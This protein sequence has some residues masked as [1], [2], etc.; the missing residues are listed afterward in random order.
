MQVPDFSEVANQ[1][2][3]HLEVRHEEIDRA[4]VGLLCLF[5]VVSV[6]QAAP[7][8]PVFP[9][10]VGNLYSFSGPFSDMGDPAD[11]R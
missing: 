7:I 2:F 8:G 5:L 3:A 10:P 6:A 9:A 11:S 4:S 1:L